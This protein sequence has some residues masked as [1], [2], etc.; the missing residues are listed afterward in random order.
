[1]LWTPDRTY[2][3][4]PF[5]EER[6]LEDAILKVSAALFGE[7]RIYLDAKR[8]IGE[9]G[10]TRN[11][12]DGYLLDLSSGRDPKLYIV[13]NELAKHDPLRHIAVQVLEFSLS[14]EGAPHVVKDIVKEAVR[15]RPEA[16]AKCQAYAEQHGYEN[17]D[18][19]LERMVFGPNRFNAL[20]II[21]EVDDDL[22]TVLISRF[23]FPVEILTLERYAGP[24]R[25]Q[26]FKFEPFLAD[27]APE[28][29]MPTLA[30]S[31]GATLDPSDIDT[32]VVPAR[33]EG[34]DE[35]FLREN[36]WYKIRIHSSMIPKIK[37]I[38]AYRITP[39][40]AITHIAPVSSIKQWRDTSKYVVNFAEPAR[41]IEPIRRVQG[42]K[43][44]ALQSPRYT[45]LA[46][47]EKAKNLDE[48]F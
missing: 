44:R 9:K 14:F 5:E 26:V 2:N 43:I 37:T 27:V 19:L 35:T 29:S 3:E 45:S 30:T 23:K 41:K 18:Y 4:L 33:E 47:L 39:E 6:E 31:S 40:Q 16:L 32:I 10:R 48:A 24:N 7:R 42:G 15:G 28:A 11:I 21:D 1:M 17:V 46:R 13:E 25:E 12:P 22:E 34:F 36:R 20:I 38:A 8:K